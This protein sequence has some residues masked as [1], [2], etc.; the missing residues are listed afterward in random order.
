MGAVRMGDSVLIWVVLAVLLFWIVGAYKRLVRLRLHAIGAFAP[1]DTHLAH[2]AALLQ[3][4]FS[5][6]LGDD[7]PPAQAGLLGAAVQLD[8]CTKA[9]RAR[10]LDELALRTLETA[11]EALCASWRRALNEPH[12]LAG[13]RLP[14]ALQLQW[15]HVARDVANARDEFNRRV[16]AYNAAIRQFP[17]RLLAAVFG[18]NPAQTL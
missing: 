12:D 13:E 11:H 7:G 14:Q 3:A 17:A 8:A 9:A 2:Y 16:T 6:A 5:S 1:L 15:E 18:F 10:P 4:S